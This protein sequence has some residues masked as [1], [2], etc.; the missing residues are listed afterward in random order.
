MEKILPRHI[1]VSCLPPN[2]EVW[3]IERILCIEGSQIALNA[4]DI[5]HKKD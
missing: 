1:P 3:A 5:A 2:L 4:G